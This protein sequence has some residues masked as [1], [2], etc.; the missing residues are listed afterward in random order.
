MRL[1]DGFE[2]AWF[3]AMLE[4][5]ADTAACNEL[6]DGY[7]GLCGARETGK[8]DADSVNGFFKKLDA[9]VSRGSYTSAAVICANAGDDFDAPAHMKPLKKE[10][11][12]LLKLKGM[13]PVI[14]YLERNKRVF[15]MKDIAYNV[16]NS[17]WEG[18]AFFYRDDVKKDMEICYR[19]NFVTP[20]MAFF[21][22]DKKRK[23]NCME[24]GAPIHSSEA[25]AMSWIS[26]MGVDS[27]RKKSN[28]WDFKPDTTICPLCAL[29]YTCLPLGFRMIAGQ[30]LFINNNESFR[31][32]VCANDTVVSTKW[33]TEVAGVERSEFNSM[34]AYKRFR[35]Y[36]YTAMSEYLHG[37]N[38][39]HAIQVIQRRSEMVKKGK[40]TE[41][42][43]TY[44]ME[45]L[46]REKLRVL[47]ECEKEFR[48]LPKYNVQLG[49]DSFLNM[50]EETIDNLVAG[51][52]QYA[53]INL[54][55]RAQIEEGHACRYLWDVLK[56]QMYTRRGEKMQQAETDYKA[57][58][59]LAWEGNGL[60][61]AIGGDGKY[62]ADGRK[63]ETETDNKLRGYIY[64][65]LNYINA[66]DKAGFQDTIIR[67][68]LGCSRS[69]PGGLFMKMLEDDET[70]VELGQAYILGLSG[71]LTR[72]KAKEE[73]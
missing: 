5:Y 16:I 13:Q 62:T 54:V 59:A 58:W 15:L 17:F 65:L 50:S 44:S 57:A 64:K 7:N 12:A 3:D 30:G 25:G 35:A 11:E 71:N 22:T 37:R 27:A 23:G 31:M 55:M 26:D 51:R 67:M 39:L 40:K 52:S 41:K 66:R 73:K 29:A 32:L 61:M 6:I 34:G 28:F 72:D 69:L 70:F 8:L 47:S 36:A 24:C 48:R 33:F 68:Y 19:K 10:K 38:E 45:R 53:L 4:R 42:Q 2:T 43:C 1:L 60:K 49:K 14:N 56:I 63:A 18:K 20:A 9:K 46:S 21:S